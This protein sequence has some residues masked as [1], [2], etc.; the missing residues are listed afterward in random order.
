MKYSIS[1]DELIAR[2]IIRKDHAEEFLNKMT[3][4][5]IGQWEKETVQMLDD[6]SIKPEFPEYNA[7]FLAKTID[8]EILYEIYR[9]KKS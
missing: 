3:D 5:E 8:Q 1:L 4:E 6:G 2:P 9:D 7:A